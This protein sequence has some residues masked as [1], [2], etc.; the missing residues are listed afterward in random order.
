MDVHAHYAGI[1]FA[2]ISGIC[3]LLA[4]DSLRGWIACGAI[5]SHG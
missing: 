5:I 1:R 2:L 3:F 4:E